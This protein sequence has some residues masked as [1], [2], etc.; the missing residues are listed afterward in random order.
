[1]R[2]LGEILSNTSPK[3]LK[4]ILSSKPPFQKLRKSKGTGEKDNRY[5]SAEHL[6][7]IKLD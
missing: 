2:F 7:E 4:R 1:M 3:E 5:L 6:G